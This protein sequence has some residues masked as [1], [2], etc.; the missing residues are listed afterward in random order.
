MLRLDEFKEWLRESTN[1]S[2]DVVGD[3]ASRMKRANKL[4]P[5]DGSETYMFYL[6]KEPGF[7]ELSI[8]VRSQIRKAVKLY[9][10]FC[11]SMS[12]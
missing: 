11:G 1:Y 5:W 12:K 3:M 4:R 10:E 7:C 2:P 9:M 8:S 6:E